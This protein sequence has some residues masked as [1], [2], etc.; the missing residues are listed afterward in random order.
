MA[1]RMAPF[2]MTLSDFQDHS[3]IIIMFNRT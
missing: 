1:Y 3:P 2:P